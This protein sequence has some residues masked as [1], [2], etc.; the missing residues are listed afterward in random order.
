[1]SWWDYTNIGADAK[2]ENK[3]FVEKIF[4]YIGYT[5]EPADTAGDYDECIF[6]DP[7][8]YGCVE[9]DYPRQSGN[10]KDCFASFDETDLLNLL[11][12]L[13]PN[14]P[15]YVHS[16]KGNDTS[17]TWEFHDKVYD[18]DT[19]TLECKDSYTDYGGGGPNGS[20]SW[21][22]RFTLDVPKLEYVEALISLS[23]AD[24]NTE[25]TGLLQDLS[26]KI[27]EGLIIYEEESTDRRIIGKK[28]DV[29]T[30]GDLDEEEDEENQDYE[31]EE[32]EE[33]DD[34]TK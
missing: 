3:G 27:Q 28:Y 21:S 6:W 11:N 12:A 2:P 1:M 31:D 26:K 32:K 8:V 25:L 29:E 30:D 15:V 17:D 9:S 14:T 7:D 4:E 5:T 18:T 34:D 23:R 33:K 19:M 13:F 24:E 22:E 10:V 16:T 20:K